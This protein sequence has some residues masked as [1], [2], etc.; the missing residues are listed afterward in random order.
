M[1]KFTIEDVKAYLAEKDL[2]HDCVLLST[3]YV[4]SKTPLLFKCNK[5]D[6]EFTRSFSNVRRNEKFTCARCSQ[7]RNL[8][9][10]DIQK[11]LQENDINHECTLLST[12]YKNVATPLRFQ[13]NICGEEFLRTTTQLK[14][15]HFRCYNCLKKLQG[16]HNRLTLIDVQQFIELNDPNNDC[17][18][19]STEYIN[20]ETP[21]LFRCNCCG[22]EFERTYATLRSK[23]AFKCFR[24]A[25]H[26]DPDK[27][28]NTY[29]ALKSYFRGKT[30]VWK[31]EFLETHQV[32]DILGAIEGAEF[33]IHHLINF[34]T[35]LNQASINTEIP[36]IYKPH[37][38]EQYGYSLEKLT[39][40]FLRLHNEASAVLLEKKLHQLFHKTYGYKNNTAEQ[41]YEFKERYLKGDFNDRKNEID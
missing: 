6:E 24:C 41:Y 25:H 39:A 38:L 11:Y 15:K 29:N 1:K 27:D 18:L 9:I 35:I 36:L 26:I 13:C 2:N 30:Y 33:D 31:K 16:G 4:D 23:K 10:E 17:E 21:L 32:C 34:S 14:E 28:P 7:G 40:E 3:E 19:L 5:C 12:K 20:Q 22:K 37:E 8:S